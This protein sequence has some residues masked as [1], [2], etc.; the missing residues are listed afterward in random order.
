M[1]CAGATSKMFGLAVLQV[2]H[3]LWGLLSV[4]NSSL[5]HLCRSHLCDAS[6]SFL[7]LRVRRAMCLG[8]RVTC[9]AQHRV[10]VMPC[11][12][13]N[14][15]CRLCSASCRDAVQCS[16]SFFGFSLLAQSSFKWS[17]WSGLGHFLSLLASAGEKLMGG[18]VVHSY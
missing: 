12:L 11:H 9:A 15:E 18:T 2:R 5:S 16:A 3:I 7:P 4:L 10:G 13:H 1:H 14:S 17:T 8:L 6:V